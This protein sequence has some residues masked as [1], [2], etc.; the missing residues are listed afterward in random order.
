MKI[1]F[2]I[3]S[4][5]MGGWLEQRW[6]PSRRISTSFPQS[7]HFTVGRICEILSEVAIKE[8]EEEEEKEREKREGNNKEKKL[9]CF[10]LTIYWI[11]EKSAHFF[12]HLC[13]VELPRAMRLTLSNVWN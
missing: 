10:P 9:L 11:F 7:E 8:R 2:K 6:S 3:G 13:K 5:G 1:P 4:A 12:G